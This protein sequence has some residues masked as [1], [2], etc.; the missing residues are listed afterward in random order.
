MKRRWLHL[1]TGAGMVCTVVG[2]R[3][4]YSEVIGP[5]RYGNGETSSTIWWA[6]LAALLVATSYGFGLPELPRRRRSAVARSV[7]ALAISLSTLSFFQLLLAQ[8]LL[9]RSA[10]LLIVSITP[11]WAVLSWNLSADLRTWSEGRDRVMIITD[12]PDDVAALRADLDGR[13]EVPAS[14]VD[15]VEPEEV[16]ASLDRPRPLAERVAASEP[17]VIVIDR[18]AQNDDR[19]IEQITT[20]HRD[21]VRVRTLALFYD[22]WLG[23][24]PIAE[25]AQVSLLFD[26]GEVHRAHYVRAKRVVDLAVGLV[27]SLLCALAIPLLLVGN[28]LG[29]RGPLLF[30][31]ERI[32]K[33]G[34][35]FTIF[36]FRTMVEAGDQT[37][38]TLS[39]DDRVTAFGRFLRRSHLDEL[40]QMVNIVRGE[41]S[42]VGPRPEQTEYVEE[43]R[44]KIPFYDE[45]HIVRPGLTGWAQVKQ[46][47]AASEGDALEKLQYD[48]HYLRRQSIAFDL[49]IVGR[50]V[51]EVVGGLGR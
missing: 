17:T 27:G 5:A 9:P 44:T 32:G 28:A 38:W 15:V 21:G 25:L 31:Q 10:I 47:Y 22:G 18:G 49:R 34:E 19:L 11:I 14:I 30:R 24:L 16:A 36:K 50:T 20:I 4:A 43:L 45:R 6:G 2:A 29:N 46:G 48:F 37:S 23:K 13:E 51:R 3:L 41:L 1:V 40:P 8:S 39:D 12:R 42:I 33:G 35:P 26:I 7:G